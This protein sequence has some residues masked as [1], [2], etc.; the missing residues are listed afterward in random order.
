[1]PSCRVYTIL[2]HARQFQVLSY[3][4]NMKTHFFEREGASFKV[5]YEQE[6]ESIVFHDIRL[7]DER[8]RPAGPNLLSFFEHMYFSLG[9]PQ[10]EG[11]ASATPALSFVASQ[12]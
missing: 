4:F 1:M 12:V 2:Q 9:E 6:D 11:H 5:L 8:Y 10:R 3:G 7:L